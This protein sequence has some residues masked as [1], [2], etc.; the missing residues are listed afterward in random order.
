[1]DPLVEEGE[2]GR[3]WIEIG[4]GARRGEEKSV[5]FVGLRSGR[6]GRGDSK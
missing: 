1:M 3:S 6:K 5:G 4:K 2:W